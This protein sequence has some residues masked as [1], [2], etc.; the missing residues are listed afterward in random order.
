MRTTRLILTCL[1]VLA[2]CSKAPAPAPQPEAEGPFAPGNE[3][4]DLSHHNGRVNWEALSTAPLDFVYLKATEGRDW[5]D[6]RFQENWLEASQRGWHVGA[7]HFYLL[8]R[9]GAAQAENFIQSVEV[10]EGALPPAVDL[11]YAHNCTP[12]GSKEAVLA[13]IR[14]FLS[15]LEAEYGAR[16]V[17][18]TTPEFHRDWLAGHFPD[19]PI[20]MRSLSG[21]PEGEVLIWQYSMKGSVPGVEG[22]VDLNR[23]PGEKA[24]APH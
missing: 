1:A 12:E 23:V 21:P 10:R 9:N 20:W 16:P 15:A 5:K 24:Q 6:T 7:Y 14:D 8:C 3:G 18:Y 11:E 13:E 17:L 19:Y 4:I 2:A 22:F